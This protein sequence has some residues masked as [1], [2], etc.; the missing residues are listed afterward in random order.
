MAQTMKVNGFKV[1]CMDMEYKFGTMEKDM[2]E[3][4]III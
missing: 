2:K 3:I 1:K 4:T